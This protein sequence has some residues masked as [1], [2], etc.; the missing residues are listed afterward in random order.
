MSRSAAKN[1]RLAAWSYVRWF[2][3]PSH[4]RELQQQRGHLD[5]VWNLTTDA[6]FA[7]FVYQLDRCKVSEPLSLWHTHL[8]LWVIVCIRQGRARPHYTKYTDIDDNAVIAY[9]SA[10]SRTLADDS[11]ACIP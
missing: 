8:H 6:D 11:F 4:P 1:R 10:K 9:V 7:L 2:R 3:A 5:V